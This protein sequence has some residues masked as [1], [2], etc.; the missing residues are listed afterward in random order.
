[1]SPQEISLQN[2]HQAAA[3]LPLDELLEL[4]AGIDAWH[5]PGCEA[6]GYPPLQVADCGHGVTLVAP[7]YGS[8]TCFPTSV[9]MAATW[10]RDLIEEVGQA[11]GRET[12]AKNCGMLLGPMV[13][14]HRLPCGGRNYESFSEDPVLAG[15][16]GAAIIRGLQSEGTGACI[17]HI[18]CNNQQQDQKQ[19]SSIVDERT[20]RE[21][22]LKPFAIA[23]EE[24]APWAVMTSYNSVNHQYP[25]DSAYWLKEVLRGEMGFTGLIVS[26]WN[27][28]QSDQVLTSSLDI[29]MPGPGKWLTPATL[30]NA[31]AEGLVSE[32]ELRER[33]ARV[34]QLHALCSP[35][36]TGEGPYSPPELDS[37]RHRALSRRVAE[38]SITLLK[39]EG[40][41]L[42]LDPNRIQRIAV[43][44]PNATSARLGGGGS[45]S[46]S[47]FYSISAL[48]GI[49]ALVG[50][51]VEVLYSEGCGLG[52]DTPVVPADAFAPLNGSFGK[53][54][55]AEYFDIDDFAAGKPAASSRTE[56]QID[57]SW[58]WA[59]P[60]NG[61]PR[62][63]YSARWSG[64]LRISESGLYQFSISTQ[65]GVARVRFNGE[66]VLDAWSNW[67]PEN[68]EDKYANRS[69]DFS[70]EYEA[71]T[72]ID[73]VVEYQ[74]TG[75]RGGIHFGWN[76]PNQRSGIAAAEDL[77]RTVDA[78]IIVAGLSN[79]YEGGA[80]DRQQFE[81]PSPQ[82][83][84]IRRVA[85][86][87]PNTTVALNN[88]TPVQM[89]PW[90]DHVPAVLEAYYPGQEGGHALARILFGKINPSGKLPDTIP[91]SWEEV[92]AM[93]HYPGKDG[94]AEYK[95]EL[96]IG[97]RHY[98]SVGIS[99]A[100]PF[101]FGLSYAKFK[102]G[103][104]SLSDDLLTESSPVTIR[105]EVSNTS[106]RSGKE[107]IQLYLVFPEARTGRP[108]KQLLDFAKHEIAPGETV[109]VA[110]EVRYKDL[111]TYD[112]EAHQWCLEQSK[113]QLAVGGASDNLQLVDIQAQKV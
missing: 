20:L 44:G 102:Y 71:G 54:L 36:R 9:G 4:F 24:A 25:S 34:L 50:D 61:V 79:Q 67:D 13:N 65:E 60:A 19:T 78:V 94:I 41:Q 57:F 47:P 74:K 92:P 43:I 28:I 3:Q 66:T 29:E 86:A 75:T 21:L 109:C 6:A 46:V 40:A 37:P 69:A 83:E 64:K 101:G 103:R 108:P 18:A 91:K 93:G 98:D 62:V 88:G 51:Q 90:I 73:L 23:L 56:P 5:F 12:R 45:A 15:K 87:N 49:R 85:V 70:A 105:V 89:H 55:S 97:Y 11:L 95:E 58:G 104:P 10:N 96:N 76:T 30:K 80:F 26:D 68:F 113:F 63:F 8:A 17:K 106:D 100:F 84:L 7:P 111:L 38:E 27:C 110:F 112:S 42:P 81:L 82:V 107:T 16:L 14:L 72:E 99:P 1:M 59:A 33:A 39:N 2:A 31:L 77:A 35:A 22:Y 52:H 53:G 32:S 48:E